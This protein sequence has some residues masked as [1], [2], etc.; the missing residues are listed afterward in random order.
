MIDQPCLK[1]DKLYTPTGIFVKVK[2]PSLDVSTFTI[3][4]CNL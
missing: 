4:F 3:G 2:E 1:I